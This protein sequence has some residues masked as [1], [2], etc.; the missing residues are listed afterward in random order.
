MAETSAPN[1][2]DRPADV[3]RL[4]QDL[5]PWAEARRAAFDREPTP[6]VDE[7]QA[8]KDGELD[9]ERAEHLRRRMAVD[10]ELA[11]LYLDLCAFDEVE[12][13]PND[14][15]LEAGRQRLA[16]ELG[17]DRVPKR[18]AEPSRVLTFPRAG[19]GWLVAALLTVSAGL[20]ILGPG[21]APSL[22]RIEVVAADRGAAAQT[23]Q[24]PADNDGLEFVLGQGLLASYRLPPGA[25]FDVTLRAG[26][27]ELETW[28][29]LR[30]DGRDNLTLEVPRRLLRPGRAH[31]L[32]ITHAGLDRPVQPWSVDTVT[33]RP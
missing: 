16:R 12:P 10:P 24:L 23:L 18:D 31:S 6:G 14:T 27:D 20:W 19:F 22:Y 21:A 7:L 33:W 28:T 32:T 1:G 29:G 15:G 17:L 4:R 25:A 30:F 3:D 2:P 26:T 13:D 9:D 5:A 11:A 8:L